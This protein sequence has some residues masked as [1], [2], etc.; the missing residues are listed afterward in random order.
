MSAQQIME[1][2]VLLLR[3]ITRLEI[4]LAATARWVTWD[5]V[6]PLACKVIVLDTI[7]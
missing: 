4:I 7:F 1:D 5:L 2:V 3:V 6:T